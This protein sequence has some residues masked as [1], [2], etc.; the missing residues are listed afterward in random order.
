MNAAHKG[1]LLVSEKP[2]RYLHVKNGRGKL[3]AIHNFF[4]KILVFFSTTFTR[5]GHFGERKKKS[6]KYILSLFEDAVSL[7]SS[8]ETDYMREGTDEL[9]FLHLPG[10]VELK[11]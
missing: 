9:D 3:F 10:R 4:T 11:S 1:G 2:W 5:K 6:L 7:S 8:K